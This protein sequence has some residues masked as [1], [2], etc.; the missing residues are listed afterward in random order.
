MTPEQLAR[1]P[2]V[3]FEIGKVVGSDQEPGQTLARISELICELTG[4][5][6]CSVMLLDGKRQRLLAKASYG[7]RT[8]R[9]HR[10]SFAI[11]E[12]VAGWVLQRGEPA[13]IP[14]VAHDP[15][16]VVLEKAKT[17]IVSLACVPIEARTE[18]VGVVTVTSG[19][20]GS[21]AS[22]DVELLRFIARTIAL[23][24]ENIRLHRVAVTDVLTGAYNREFLQQRLPAEIE[25]AV[26]GDAPLSVAMIDVD[27]FKTVN[28]RFGHDG[29]D[30]VLAEVASRLRAAI[31]GDD[32]L[33]RYGGEEFL[34]VLPRA[35]AGKAWEIAERI[36]ARLAARRI[37]VDG[38]PLTIAVSIGVAQ[39]RHDGAAVE[40]APEL[41]RRADTALYAAKAQGRDRVEVAP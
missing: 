9:I 34:V 22:H 33:I 24:V 30:E 12:G 14:D 23:D 36:R 19:K 13:L 28:D 25:R 21:F 18:R 35:D 17:P 29:G 3:L 15:R 26:A 31:R 40:A 39:L 2:G 7:L 20:V 16:F 1:L 41:I 8:E 6:A 38:T 4:A 11:G 5:D 27:H 32:L 10:L 37:E